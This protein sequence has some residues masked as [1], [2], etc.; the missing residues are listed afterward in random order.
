MAT[1]SSV[2]AYY[3]E[4]RTKLEQRLAQEEMDAQG[5]GHKRRNN[6]YKIACILNKH[7]VPYKHSITE[8]II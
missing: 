7:V 8:D 1:A 4:K 6:N 3:K 5:G 2:V